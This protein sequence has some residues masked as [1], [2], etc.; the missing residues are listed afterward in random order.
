[1]RGT[2]PRRLAASRAHL[3]VN[4]PPRKEVT[5]APEG[6]SNHVAALMPRSWGRTKP[7]VHQ[8]GQPHGK[9]SFFPLLRSATV[10]VEQR[11][12]TRTVVVSSG[13]A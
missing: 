9:T 11:S 10:P 3:F 7:A 12:P 6:L 4:G 2:L 13:C 8:R 1:M 5:A